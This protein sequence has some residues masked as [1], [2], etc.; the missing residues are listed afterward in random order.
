MRTKLLVAVGLTVVMGLSSC[1]FVRTGEVEGQ[2]PVSG[3]AGDEARIAALLAETYE[4]KFVPLLRDKAVDFTALRTVLSKGLDEAGKASGVRAGGAG[5]SWNFVIKGTVKILQENRQSK[6]GTATIDVDGDGGADATLQLGPVV[7]GS[8][9][10]DVAPAIYDFS[11]FRDQIEFAKLGRALN[12]Q[13]VS[14]LPAGGALEGKTVSFI[15][16]A[17]I[18]SANEKP[19]IVPVILE[20]G[21]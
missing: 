15:G 17:S 10:R 6:A 12:D 3:E 18:R 19:L 20:V 8:A 9:L 11:K 13:A 14:S 2:A 4:A 5:G 16:A 21:Q 7:K 1:K